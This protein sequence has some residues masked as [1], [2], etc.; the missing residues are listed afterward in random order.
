MTL[1]SIL[2]LCSVPYE[3]NVGCNQHWHHEMTM[4]YSRSNTFYNI[5]PRK[6]IARLASYWHWQ[7]MPTGSPTVHHFLFH[8]HHLCLSGL[9]MV[10]FLPH[11]FV[12]THHSV[13][14]GYNQVTSWAASCFNS[15]CLLCSWCIHHV[16]PA[17]LI[18][19]KAS[20]RWMNV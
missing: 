15:L 16:D 8:L 2:E 4:E 1:L 19:S 7:W 9:W 12:L 5:K 10:T 18:D 11:S 17:G 13:Y 20:V 6:M 3:A 14:H